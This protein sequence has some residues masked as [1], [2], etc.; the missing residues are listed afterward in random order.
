MPTWKPDNRWEGQ[1][2]YVV[3]GGA[4]LAGFDF[5]VLRGHNTVGCNSA[6]VL[7]PDLCQSVVF[8]DLGWWTKIGREG[9]A[10]Y[11]HPNADW[12]AR[13]R[14]GTRAHGGEVISCM[15][16]TRL[17]SLDDCP[18]VLHAPRAAGQWVGDRSLGWYGNTGAL[19]LN[20][21][22]VYGARRVFLLGYD[23]ELTDGR[24]NWHG[25]R[26]EPVNGKPLN[27][28][29]KAFSVMAE[30]VALA[31]PEAEVVQVN[32]R[33]GLVT[34]DGRDVFPRQSIHEHFACEVTE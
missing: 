12:Q 21:A 19:A 20:L 32:D 34:D 4:S 14:A 24:Q 10:D 29:R 7:G 25:L 1:D 16:S 15:S 22:L 8:G 3:G 33:L 26:Y 23:M 2:A 13:G 28:F 31:F 30:S 11:A 9:K 17:S 5:E 27:R 6:F 18:W